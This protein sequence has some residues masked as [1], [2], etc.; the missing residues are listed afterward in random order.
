MLTYDL[1]LDDIILF[2][3]P[4]FNLSSPFSRIV[5]GKKAI[6][7][8]L[9]KGVLKLDGVEVDRFKSPRTFF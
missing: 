6:S 4:A 1:R 3:I 5:V 2:F 8:I 7:I 9:E